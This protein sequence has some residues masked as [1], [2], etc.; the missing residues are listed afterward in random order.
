MDFNK[1]TLGLLNA[2]KLI[3]ASNA[4]P[5]QPKF[6]YEPID[7]VAVHANRCLTSQE[8]QELDTTLMAIHDAESVEEQM[9]VISRLDGSKVKRVRVKQ[10]VRIDRSRYTPEKLREIRAAGGG[11]KERDRAARRAKGGELALAA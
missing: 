1:I 2:I 7:V 6:K 9:E 10:E 11:A 5:A 8:R 3:A 4:R